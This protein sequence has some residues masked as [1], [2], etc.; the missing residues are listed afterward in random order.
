MSLHFT[1]ARTG[2]SYEKDPIMAART[3][4]E[5]LVWTNTL[6]GQQIRVGWAGRSLM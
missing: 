5:A 3:S 1:A 2:P 4:H 6:R